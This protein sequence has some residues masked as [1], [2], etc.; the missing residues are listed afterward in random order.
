VTNA[1]A[2][3]FATDHGRIVTN[4]PSRHKLILVP[5]PPHV[6]YNPCTRLIISRDGSVHLDLERCIFGS[7]WEA[8]Y[9]P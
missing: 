7:G 2:H 5:F 3:W 9:T 4:E 8:C 1:T 6:V